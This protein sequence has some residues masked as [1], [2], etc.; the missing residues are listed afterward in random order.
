MQTTKSGHA[1]FIMNPFSRI[2]L[3]MH[4]SVYILIAEDKPNS[5]FSL[6]SACASLQCDF[7]CRSP[8]QMSTSTP[9]KSTLVFD[10]K[11]QWE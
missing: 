7:V 11:M 1:H 4:P 6:Y 10:N 9:F 3:S 2:S 8:N 5:S